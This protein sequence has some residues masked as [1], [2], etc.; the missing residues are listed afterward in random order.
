MKRG[1]DIEEIWKPIEGYEG[2]YEVSNIGRVRSITRELPRS[3]GKIQIRNGRIK[4]QYIN[5]DG[6]PTVKL[7]K[8]KKDMRIAVH[9]LVAF[10]FVDGYFVGAEVNHKDCNRANNVYTNLEWVTHYDNIKYSIDSGNHVSVSYDYSGKSNPNYGNRVLK[11]R[12]VNDKELSRIKQGRK[13]SINGRA[14]PVILT[15]SDGEEIRFSYIGECVNYLI[16]NSFT[17]SKNINCVRTAITKSIKDNRNYNG[18]KFK[19]I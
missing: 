3:D 6:Y 1:I 7:S 9:R 15:K 18:M 10:A 19:F 14:K 16:E 4:S 12:Y 2:Y 13:G 5:Q 11:E 8:S 17:R